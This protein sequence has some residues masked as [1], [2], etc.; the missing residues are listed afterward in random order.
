MS[1][2]EKYLQIA[3]KDIIFGSE[4][5]AAQSPSYNIDTEIRKLMIEERL[6]CGLTQKE[7]A[8]RAHILMSF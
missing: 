7:L 2:L 3:L 4:E 5:P 1:D 6:R 8:K